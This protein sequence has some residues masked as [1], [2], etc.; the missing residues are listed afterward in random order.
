MSKLNAQK[1]KITPAETVQNLTLNMN[2]MK[3]TKYGLS[4]EEIE[5]RSLASERFKT[6][7]NMHRIE[8][9]QRLHRR[10]DKY[11]VMKYSAKR[12]K[13]RERL[14]VGETVLVLA[15][16]I[17]KKAAPGKFY[18]QSVENV[19]FFNKDKTFIIRKIRTIDGIKYYWLEDAQNNKK[20][21]KRFQR[22]ELFAVRGNFVV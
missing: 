3:S 1:V 13:L 6:V 18:K 2:P 19:S 12:K 14:F 16:R 4:P 7:F 5:K 15:E 9:T 20:L 22:T 17:K 8:K 21:T 10:L 11:D